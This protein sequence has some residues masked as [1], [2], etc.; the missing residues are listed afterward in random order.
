MKWSLI[1]FNLKDTV[2]ELYDLQES[3]LDSDNPSS[4]EL[5]EFIDKFEEAQCLLSEINNK[6]P[7]D[8]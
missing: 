3:W 4:D 2:D 7:D 8:D 6:L 1:V 5:E